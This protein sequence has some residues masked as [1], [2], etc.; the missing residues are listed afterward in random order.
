[1]LLHNKYYEYMSNLIFKKYLCTFFFS[2][3]C[4]GKEKKSK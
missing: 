4:D 2:L 1:M 3:Y